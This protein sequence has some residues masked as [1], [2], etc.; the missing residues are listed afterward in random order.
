M[1]KPNDAEVKTR[2][3]FDSIAKSYDESFDGKFV[4]CLYNEVAARVSSLKQPEAILDLGCG[5]G[6]LTKIISA[7]TS[8]DLYGLDLS[9]QMVQEAT[10][11][12]QGRAAFTTGNAENLPYE[13]GRFDAVVC[14]ASFHHYTKPHKVIGEIKRVLK[15]GGVFILGD[16]TAPFFILK[17]LNWILQ[18]RDSGDAHIYGQKEITSMLAQEGFLIDNWKQLG[19]HTFVLNASLAE[20][21]PGHP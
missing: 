3:Y 5:N 9:V 17:L 16:P 6:N 2:E 12:L 19:M 13:N 7:A 11:R 10:A 14:N 8:A 4:R 15:P 1:K 18:F 21:S 20:A